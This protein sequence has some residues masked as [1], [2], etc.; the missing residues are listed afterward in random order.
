MSM[1]EVKLGLLV[2]VLGL[3]VCVVVEASSTSCNS[4]SENFEDI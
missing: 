1:T 3:E 4:R 2:S